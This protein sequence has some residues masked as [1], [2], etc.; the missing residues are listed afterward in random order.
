MARGEHWFKVLLEDDDDTP[1]GNLLVNVTHE[2]II[3]DLYD[4]DKQE[5]LGT[6]GIMAQ[7]IA[8]EWCLWTGGS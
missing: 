7:D 6:M 3:C 5:C 8:D 2:G 4:A 1:T